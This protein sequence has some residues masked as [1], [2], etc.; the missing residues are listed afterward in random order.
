MYAIHGFYKIASLDDFE[1][2]EIGGEGEY[3]TDVS[4]SIEDV[5]LKG[6]LEK[7][8]EALWVDK[9]EV[10]TDSCEEIGRVDFCRMENAEGDRPS[11][12]EIE[13]WKKGEVKLYNVVYS[14]TVV[15]MSPV[16]VEH[17]TL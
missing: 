16:S 15:D 17:I 14:G 10:I 4:I 8:C 13:R 3:C 9:E 11:K 6:L 12:T 5:T 2:G 1:K 7:A